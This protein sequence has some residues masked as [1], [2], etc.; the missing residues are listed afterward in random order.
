MISPRLILVGLWLAGGSLWAAD[1]LPT[2]GNAP[3]SEDDQKLFFDG[4]K[5]VLPGSVEAL[6]LPLEEQVDV[7]RARLDYERA[8]RQQTRWQ[9]LGKAGVLA[10][11]EVERAV[12]QTARLRVRMEKARVAAQQ[13][14]LES[15]RE[16][17]KAGQSSPDSVAAAESALTTAQAI[18]AEADSALQRT[19]LLQAEVNLERQRKLRAAGVGSKRQLERAQAE[20]LRIKQAAQ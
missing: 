12:L 9:K 14:A 2:K 1:E 19:V 5:D 13:R 15:L 8:L 6:E 11:V 18:S 20:L 17:V 3:L 4:L 16:R 7:E 10:Q